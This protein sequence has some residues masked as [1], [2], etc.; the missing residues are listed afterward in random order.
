MMGRKKVSQDRIINN[1]T[2]RFCTKCKTWKTLEI[3]F[4]HKKKIKEGVYIYKSHCKQC[5]VHY[6]RK[7]NF[8]RGHKPSLLLY[9]D[10]VNKKIAKLE[11]RREKLIQQIY[12]I[13]KGI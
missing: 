4:S 8:K 3:D 7:G 10:S 5:C 1:V 11:T 9:L 13:T 6:A 12:C 2:E